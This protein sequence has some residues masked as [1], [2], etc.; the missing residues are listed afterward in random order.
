MCRESGRKEN[1]IM[2][3]MEVVLPVS[4]DELELELELEDLWIGYYE[5]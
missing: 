2:E 3:N 5:V 1:A 4:D